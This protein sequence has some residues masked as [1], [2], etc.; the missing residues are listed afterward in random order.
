MK[1]LGKIGKMLCT[2]IGCL[3]IIVV[4]CVACSSS[5][6]TNNVA[7]SDQESS[8]EKSE[9]K[10]EFIENPELVYENY[11]NKIVGII[12]NNSGSDKGYIQ[13]SFTLYDADGNNVGSAL[14]NTNN[15]KADG[16]WKFEAIVLEDDVKSFEL[17][18]V[19]GF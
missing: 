7:S 17:D 18:E 3:V 5:N 11:T 4:L 2:L 8:T 1:F 9:A 19:S 10:Y 6:S 13:I 12:K 16:T 15:L 14:A